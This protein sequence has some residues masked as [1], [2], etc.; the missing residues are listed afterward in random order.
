MQAIITKYYGP[1]NTKGA[2]I[3]AKCSAGSFSHGYHSFDGDVRHEQDRHHV[4]ARMLADRL[5]WN[6]DAYGKIVT[7]QLHTGDYVHVFTEGKL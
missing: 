7:G 6:T 3:V 2:R 1:T 4:V 5:G